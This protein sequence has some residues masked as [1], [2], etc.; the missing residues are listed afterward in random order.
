MKTVESEKNYTFSDD[1]VYEECTKKISDL[2]EGYSNRITAVEEQKKAE[3]EAEA[4]KKA[5]EE[6][7][8][9]AEEKA[10][11]HYENEYFSVD[12]PSD[13]GSD[14]TVSEEDNSLNGVSSILYSFSTSSGGATVYVLDMSDTS[15]PLSEYSRMIPSTCEEV[16]VT[17]FGYYDVF[18]T[19]AGAGFF[20]AG[21]TI[22]L[23]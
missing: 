7:R 3:A 12:V 13:W 8:R 22:A 2:T 5:E 16:G 9:Q 17:S 1:S 4:K 15:R 23:K 14:W 19:E 6:A 18:K 21:A 20:S 10:K 11:T